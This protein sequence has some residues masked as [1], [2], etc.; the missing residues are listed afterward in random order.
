[1]PVPTL[2]RSHRPRSS[3]TLAQTSSSAP[4]PSF[5]S[6]AVCGLRVLGLRTRELRLLGQLPPENA[7]GSLVIAATG[8]R[9]DSVTWRPA[10]LVDEIPHPVRRG[11]DRSARGLAP[12]ACVHQRVSPERP[13]PTWRPR[14]R[15]PRRRQARRS[16]STRDRTVAAARAA[17]AL[18]RLDNAR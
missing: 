17:R 4:S 13:S 8:R 16:P 9:I 3:C 1:M 2:S 15:P 11:R 5:C 7:S 6:V 10:L 12:G 14:G 18:R